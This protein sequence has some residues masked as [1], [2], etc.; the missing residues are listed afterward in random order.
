MMGGYWAYETLGWGGYW[1]WDPVENSS[2]VPWLFSIGAIHTFLSQR[3]SGA[4]VRTNLVLSMLCFLFVLYATFLTRSGVLG[5]TSVHSFVDPGMWA[6]WLLIGMIVL[7]AVLGFGL[8]LKRRKE[9][10]KVAVQHDYMSREFAL[11]LGSSALVFAA[12]FIIVGTSS[13]IITGIL[14]GKVTAVDISYYVTT[15]LPLGI[16]IGLLSGIGQLLWWTRSKKADFFK[17]LIWPSSLALMCTV[18]L[19]FVG[20]SQIL[21]AVYRYGVGVSKIR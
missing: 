14:Y 7:F 16:A 17:S 3:K 1:G 6:Y 13:P 11:F 9:M 10:P 21:V 20:L 5:D 4:F 18:G 8:M 19:S 2:L 15:T 12:I